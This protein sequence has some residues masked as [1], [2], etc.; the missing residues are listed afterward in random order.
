MDLPQQLTAQLK[1]MERLVDP[2]TGAIL[3]RHPVLRGIPDLVLEGD[4]YTLEFIGPTLLCLDIQ[5]PIGMV[6][7]LAEPLKDLLPVGV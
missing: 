1:G 4:G 5:D 3:F 7:L 6:R 2:D